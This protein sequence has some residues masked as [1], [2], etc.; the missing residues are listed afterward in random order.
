MSYATFEDEE[1]QLPPPTK[2]TCSIRRVFSV[3]LVV[4]VGL[5]MLAAISADGGISESEFEDALGGE[6]TAAE[7]QRLFVKLDHNRDGIVSSDE[8][9]RATTEYDEESD[10]KRAF[11]AGEMSLIGLF[12]GLGLVPWWW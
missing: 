3:V 5:D 11:A 8:I 10:V 4:T 7:L 6:V 2:P 1:A 9:K 12:N